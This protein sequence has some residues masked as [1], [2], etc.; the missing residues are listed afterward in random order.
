MGSILM[1]VLLHRKSAPRQYPWFAILGICGAV[2][3]C[4]TRDGHGPSLLTGAGLAALICWLSPPEQ[5]NNA[6]H[7]IREDARARAL[8][9]SGRVR[10]L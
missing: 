4:F 10:E 5:P 7:A 3:M 6:L 9:A 1:Y 2:V 8:G